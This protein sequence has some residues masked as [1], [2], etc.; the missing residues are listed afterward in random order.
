[1]IELTD[2]ALK[3]ALKLGATDVSTICA[4]NNENQIRFSN[5][6]ITVTKNVKS[7]ELFL[8]IAKDRK[9]I[10]G[11]TSN[12]SVN[13]IKKFTSDLIKACEVISPSPDYTLLPK[14][15]FRYLLHGVHDKKLVEDELTLIEFAKEAIDAGLEAGATR[16][17]GSLTASEEKLSILTSGGASGE[18]NTTKILLNVR[19]FIEKET[20]GHGLSCAAKLTDFKPSEAGRTAGDYAK[21][22][23]NPDHWEEG[24]YDLVAI[25]TV[26]ADIIQHIGS[27]SSAFMVDAGISFFADKV[28][29]KVG[30]D[31]FTLRDYGVAEGGFGGRAFDD[32]GVPTRENII[33]ENGVLEGYLHNSTTARKF[34]TFTTGNAGIIEPH[35]WNLVVD[36]GKTSEEELIKEVKRGILVTNNWY[37]RFQNMRTGTFST[38]PRDAT[39]LIENGRIKYPI[40]GLRISDSIPRQ[41]VNILGISK[42]RRWIE[43]WEVAI[44]TL[45]P[46][47]LI[48]DVT[49]TKAL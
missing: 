20:S 18:D 15:E 13:G 44:P 9:R 21:I 46:A 36:S 35:P 32:E 25:P 49:V 10:L 23:T 8:Y 31:G 28:G 16:V 11:S 5:N 24:Q 41:L 19:A 1:M 17:S 47:M 3:E 42:E 29:Q 2:L 7:L 33:I 40:T 26:T 38:I 48:K 34:G 39:F 4:Q 37:T 45:A 6:S 12:L 27:F 43:W 22:S 30:V 14:G